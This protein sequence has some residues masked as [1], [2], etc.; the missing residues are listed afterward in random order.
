MGR[1]YDF[2]IKYNVLRVL[3]VVSIVISGTL[4][5]IGYFD[6]CSNWKYSVTILSIIM[7]AALVCKEILEPG[8]RR[9]H[10][11]LI[12]QNDR[13]LPLLSNIEKAFELWLEQILE[14]MDVDK[15]WRAS[16]YIFDEG[17]GNEGCFRFV[18]RESKDPI[19]KKRGR[20]LFN[21]NQGVIGKAWEKGTSYFTYAPGKS[22]KNRDAYVS[23][24][25]DKFN[26]DYKT[27]IG[28]KM[29]AGVI[30]GHVVCD[31]ADN[32]CGV[33]IV[34][35]TSGAN[36]NSYSSKKRQQ[37]FKNAVRMV[38]NSLTKLAKLNSDYILCEEELQEE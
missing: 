14:L 8:I 5:V 31:D 4:G 9:R 38:S 7:M 20:T 34:E 21:A 11:H 26:Y 15:T 37:K 17:K 29:V 19:L 2:L 22:C 18:A 35:S 16:F 24:L 12:R 32:K 1:F 6:K 10:N 25:M 30:M 3:G 23:W 36:A 28:I 33:V 27:A 13:L